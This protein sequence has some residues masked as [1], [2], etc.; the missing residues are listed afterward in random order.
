[1]KKYACQYAIARFLPYVETGEFANVGIVM[2]CPEKNY[3]DFRLLGNKTKRITAFFEELQVNVYRKAQGDFL[4]ELKRI[5]NYIND[6]Q[7]NFTTPPNLLNNLFAELVRPREVMI[8]FDAIRPVL[9]DDPV[10]KLEELFS[11]YVERSFST[12]V[13]QEALIEK[14]IRSVLK[15]ADLLKK[16]KKETLGNKDAYRATF[17]FVYFENDLAKRVIKPLN[18]SQD[19]PAAIYDHGWAWLGKIRKL[20]DLNLLTDDVLFAVKQPNQQNYAEYDMFNEV[21]DTL[22]KDAIK[23][24]LENDSE[25]VLD[26]ARA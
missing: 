13:Y 6:N 24:A 15:N 17:P 2:V 18:L 23:I 5:Q 9:T 4:N 12:P 11:F 21:V 3:F 10:L 22:K 14:N 25:A 19:D 7:T 1:M 8:Y 26:F 20:R 16:Y